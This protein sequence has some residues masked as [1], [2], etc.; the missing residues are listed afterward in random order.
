MV[1]NGGG[2]QSVELIVGETSSLLELLLPVFLAWKSLN[3][4]SLPCQV[5]DRHIMERS[6]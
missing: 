2:K 4:V 5:V 3:L 6:F 1:D